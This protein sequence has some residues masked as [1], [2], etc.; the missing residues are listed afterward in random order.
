MVAVVNDV[1]DIDGGCVGIDGGD[2]A[3]LA[4]VGGLVTMWM[5]QV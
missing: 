5:G 2:V 4:G 1:V 3:A